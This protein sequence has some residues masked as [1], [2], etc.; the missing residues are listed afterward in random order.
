[1]P[2]FSSSE[3]YTHAPEPTAILPKWLFDAALKTG[4][5]KK[6]SDNTYRNILGHRII[7]T[8]HLNS[9]LTIKGEYAISYSIQTN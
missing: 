7:S 9:D 2:P 6:C 3:R 5:I 1:M 4:N 8:E